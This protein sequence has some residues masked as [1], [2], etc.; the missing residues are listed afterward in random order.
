[1][2]QT[3]EGFNYT[4]VVLGGMLIVAYIYWY[5]P[6]PYGARHFFVGPKRDDVAS[7]L[8]QESGDSSIDA[9]AIKSTI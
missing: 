7:K 2:H 3:A 4:C 5:L 8:E 1:M 6:A 9:A